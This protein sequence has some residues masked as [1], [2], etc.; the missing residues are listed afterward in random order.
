MAFKMKGFPYKSGFKHTL[1]AQGHEHVDA[2]ATKEEVVEEK[3][4]GDFNIPI[5][6]YGTNHSAREIEIAIS[7]V[8]SYHGE[9]N[10]GKI[11]SWLEGNPSHDARRVKKGI[12]TV[13]SLYGG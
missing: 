6:Q 8:K 2:E 12:G 4:E 7:E 13:E 10:E 9:A 5:N 11:K 3:S 1:E